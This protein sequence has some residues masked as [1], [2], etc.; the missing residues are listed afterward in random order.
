M[1]WSRDVALTDSPEQQGIF[2]DANVVSVTSY[3]LIE[4]SHGN[5]IVKK[6]GNN[7]NRSDKLNRISIWNNLIRLLTEDSDIAI[8][9]QESGS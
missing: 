5:E 2:C 1:L 9:R 8:I 4:H 6:D 3:S 7:D